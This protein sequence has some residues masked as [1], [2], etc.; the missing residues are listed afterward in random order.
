MKVGNMA[1]GIKM[2]QLL[3]LLR[4]HFEL[5]FSQRDISKMISISKTTVHNYIRLYNL[6]TD[7][8]L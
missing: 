5:N 8:F 7:K 2:K 6:R 3:E 4:L 1:K